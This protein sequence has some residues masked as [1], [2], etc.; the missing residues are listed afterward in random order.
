[1]AFVSAIWALSGLPSHSLN[2]SLRRGFAWAYWELAS[3]FGVLEPLS[4]QWRQPLLDALLP[5]R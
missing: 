2:S 5:A 1:M 4:L 3:S